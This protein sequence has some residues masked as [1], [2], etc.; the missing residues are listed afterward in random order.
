MINWK[1]KFLLITVIIF[2]ELYVCDEYLK[3]FF[4]PG[5]RLGKKKPAKEKRTQ[6]WCRYRDFIEINKGEKL[7]AKTLV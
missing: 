1:K 3:T 7:K 6:W 4:L 2:I 5:G